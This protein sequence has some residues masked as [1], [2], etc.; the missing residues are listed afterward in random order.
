MKIESPC[1]G[2]CELDKTGA[3]CI[4]CFR[5]INEITNWKTFSEEEKTTTL[6]LL[7]KRKK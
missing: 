6:K 3:F 5:T 4:G 2:L 7:K 1:I